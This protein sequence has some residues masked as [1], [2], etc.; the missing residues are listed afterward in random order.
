MRGTNRD[1]E[2]ERGPQ[3]H[4]KSTTASADGGAREDVGSS[5]A[6]RAMGL[7]GTHLRVGIEAHAGPWPSHQL[8]AYS[9]E[10]WA[11]KGEP[12][13]WCLRCPP[14]CNSLV[15]EPRPAVLAAHLKHVGWE[16]AWLTIKHAVDAALHLLP[17]Q[18]HWGSCRRSAGASGTAPAAARPAGGGGAGCRH[19]RVGVNQVL[20][21]VGH[22]MQ[23][24]VEQSRDQRKHCMAR[25]GGEGCISERSPSSL[26]LC[27]LPARR[28]RSSTRCRFSAVPKQYTWMGILYVP[29]AGWMW[30][31]KRAG[32]G[33]EAG[34][35]D[36]ARP[37]AHAPRRRRPDTNQPRVSQQA[38][39]LHRQ[40]QRTSAGH[41][42]LQVQ[43]ALVD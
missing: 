26:P 14:Q 8:C 35:R 40:H 29:L 41:Q 38:S 25:T 30:S 5:Q 31:R 13:S 10:A 19:H 23:Q 43:G 9:R 28:R 15:P 18:R 11:W 22:R 20:R 36:A 3:V 6:E 17:T 32:D 27:T 2:A 16:Q 39:Q 34:G 4:G 21:G 24:W 42:P 12:A 7:A 1:E 37:S 33:W